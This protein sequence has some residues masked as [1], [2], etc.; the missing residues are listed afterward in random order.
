VPDSP[1]RAV[2]PGLRDVVLHDDVE[3]PARAEAGAALAR[4]ARRGIA[5]Y[6]MRSGSSHSPRIL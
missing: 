6:P 5:A 3:V 1:D 2:V 4:L